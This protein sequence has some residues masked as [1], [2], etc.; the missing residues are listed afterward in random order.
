MIPL[1]RTERANSSSASSR[2]WLRGW[3]G[4]GSMRAMSNSRVTGAFVG[5]ISRAEATPVAGPP[6]GAFGT[7]V[8]CASCSRMSAPGL[9]PHAVLGLADYLLRELFGTFW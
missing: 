3:Y 2:K 5:G 9:R 8:G 6:A 4:L 1:A 7:G